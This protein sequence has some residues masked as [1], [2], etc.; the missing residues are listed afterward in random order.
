ML[1]REEPLLKCLIQRTVEEQVER[2][3]PPETMVLLDDISRGIRQIM[4]HLEETTM[5]G[6]DV[7]LPEKVVTS[8]KPEIIDV[9]HVP[10]RSIYFFNKGPNTVYYRINN[11]STE[12]SIEDREGVTVP[13][14]RRTIVKITLR[15]NAG[16]SA[17]VKMSGRY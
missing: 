8:V 17:T 4:K 13:R 14:P 9:A 15:V 1:S 10:L 5:Q 7:P 3:L 11:D 2:I 16:K 12:V 6:V